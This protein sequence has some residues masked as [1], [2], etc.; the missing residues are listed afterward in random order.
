MH[1]KH[2]IPLS[3]L[4]V[5]LVKAQIAQARPGSWDIDC[6]GIETFCVTI[7]GSMHI[8]AFSSAGSRWGGDRYCS[9]VTKDASG[10]VI[11]KGRYGSGHGKLL[12]HASI[13]TCA[14]STYDTFTASCDKD[15]RHNYVKV[16]MQRP[17]EFPNKVTERVG[18]VIVDSFAGFYLAC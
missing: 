10:K 16:T 9:E 2:I 15:G 5:S 12:T 6:S 17:P 1:L 4:L 3:F 14:F 8:T 18:K 7:G 11:A 13:G